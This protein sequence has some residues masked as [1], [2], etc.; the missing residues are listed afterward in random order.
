MMKSAFKNNDVL[1]AF[2]NRFV[3]RSVPDMQNLNA[4]GFVADVVEMRYGRTTISRS[5]PFDPRGYAGPIYG[6]SAST[7]TC[8]SMPR[9]I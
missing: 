2:E 8:A 3:A 6:K 9:P 1:P 5:V 7:R 4:L